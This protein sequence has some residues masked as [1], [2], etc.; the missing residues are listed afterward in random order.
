M[1][2]Y[3]QIE[4]MGE[5]YHIKL[6]C[7]EDEND[8]IFVVWGTA[9]V[10]KRKHLK[11]NR[12]ICYHDV[13]QSM[14]AYTCVA[15]FNCTIP[16]TLYSHSIDCP[17][18]PTTTVT[19]NRGPN[20]GSGDD[21]AGPRSMNMYRTMVFLSFPCSGCRYCSWKFCCAGAWLAFHFC[22]RIY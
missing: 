15:K 3:N 12:C 18:P 6:S 10:T 19:N 14:Y 17:A 8:Y 16:G 4:Y 1:L 11:H 5:L 21:N 9:N 13:F 22:F 20:K 7:A 2:A